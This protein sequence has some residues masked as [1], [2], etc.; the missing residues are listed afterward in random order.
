[1]GSLVAVVTCKVD[2]MTVEM[3]DAWSEAIFQLLTMEK[4]G[5]RTYILS[6][7]HGQPREAGARVWRQERHGLQFTVIRVL[8]ICST[9]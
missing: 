6:K 5:G 2:W 7:R 4:L 1:M 8:L 9:R 3:V